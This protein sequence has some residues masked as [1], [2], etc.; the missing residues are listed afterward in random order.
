MRRRR[1]RNA[2][3][4]LLVITFVGIVGYLLGWSKALEI[5]HIELSAAGNETLV[6]PILVPNDLHIGLPM[7]RVSN[8]RITHDLARFTWIKDIRVDRRWLAHDVKIT[9]SERK[10]VAQYVD[11]QG[12]TQYF[13][14]KGYNFTTPIPPSGIP[15]IN[16]AQEGA[17]PRGAV[18]TFLAQT[19]SDIT[20]NMSG[21]A[22]DAHNQISLR[23]K[24]AGYANLSIAWGIASD[25]ALKVQ[26]LRQLLTLPENKKIISVDLSS[27][28]TPV[29]K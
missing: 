19:P 1:Y 10:A 25:L 14:G 24:L 6:L 7:A 3:A 26:V 20:S 16:F 21:L 4:I 17:E 5:R 2:P 18:A 28:L 15:T 8:Q 13:D 23:T 22:V 9:I 27:P 11:G 12:I 29:V